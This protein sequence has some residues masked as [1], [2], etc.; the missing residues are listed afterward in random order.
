VRQCLGNWLARV[1][2]F[3]ASWSEEFLAGG[4]DLNKG[5]Q[6]DAHE[7]KWVLDA[8][9]TELD[10]DGACEPPWSDEEEDGDDEGGGACMGSAEQTRTSKKRRGKGSQ[11]VVELDIDDFVSPD[12]Q[13]HPA[14]Y[15][16]T[17]MYLHS[18]ALLQRQRNALLSVP[19]AS[20]KKYT[21]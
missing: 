1:A 9:C 19:S 16:C 21:I 17:G 13:L 20:T 14:T 15:Q 8:N 7:N 2:T 18:G 12:I 5:L 11:T 10:G 6:H 4:G 3:Q